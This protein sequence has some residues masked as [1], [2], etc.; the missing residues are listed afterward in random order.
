MPFMS[1]A[2]LF[3]LC[4][5]MAGLLIAIALGVANIHMLFPLHRTAILMPGQNWYLSNTQ[6][7]DISITSDY[8]VSVREGYCYFP[9]VASI[10]LRC[11][12]ADIE[13]TDSRPRL[14]IWAQS[15]RVNVT[16]R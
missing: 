13:I 14:L 7:S 6:Y 1:D 5:L 11:P 4:A 9:R 2:K 16:A 3:G 8:P 15:N 12:A 10:R